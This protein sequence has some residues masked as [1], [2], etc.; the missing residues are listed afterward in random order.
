MPKGRDAEAVG[1]LDVLLLCAAPVDVRPAPN[2]AQGI[3]NF[4]HEVRRAPIPIRPRRVFPPTLE[5]PRRALSPA[6]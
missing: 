6:A 5:Q 2:L 4:E 3:A 1:Y